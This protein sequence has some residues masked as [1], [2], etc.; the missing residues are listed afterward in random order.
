MLGCIVCPVAFTIHTGLNNSGVS[1]GLF[2]FQH[3]ATIVSDNIEMFS[4]LMAQG[5]CVCVCVE[6]MLLFQWLVRVTAC[7][8]ELPFV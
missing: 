1:V 5:V 2:H 4:H 3:L 7:P 6:L 8:T